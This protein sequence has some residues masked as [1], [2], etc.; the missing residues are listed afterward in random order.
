MKEILMDLLKDA[1][2]K[3][4][5]Q[6][7]RLK[8]EVGTLDEELIAKHL[9]MK[10]EKRRLKDEMELKAREIELRFKREVEEVMEPLTESLDAAHD[11]FWDA[12]TEKFGLNPDDELNI[13]VKAKKVYRVIDTPKVNSRFMQ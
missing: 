4:E 11:E 6:D 7:D 9:K 2:E 13:D 3:I 10:K 5:E 12:V 1:M 8:V